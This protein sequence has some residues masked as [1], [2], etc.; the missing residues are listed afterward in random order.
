MCVYEFALNCD[1]KKYFG[2]NN[3]SAG[4]VRFLNLYPL[5]ETLGQ[6][7]PVIIK[8]FFCHYRIVVALLSCCR[9]I[10]LTK[11][12]LSATLFFSIGCTV[13]PY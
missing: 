11:I 5:F 6:Q 3:F 1:L 9:M 10:P 13:V 4:V 2:V 7:A 8:D 12:T